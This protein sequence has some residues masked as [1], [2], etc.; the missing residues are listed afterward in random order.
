[1]EDEPPGAAQILVMRQQCWKGSP[2]WGQGQDGD[3]ERGALVPDVVLP[4]VN[5]DRFTP[6]GASSSVTG[7]TWA[8]AP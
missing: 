1:M 3:W 5:Q 2:W 7:G 6:W 4:C 8:D